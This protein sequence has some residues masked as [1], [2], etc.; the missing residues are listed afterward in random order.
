MPAETTTPHFSWVK[1]A[2]GGDASTWGV[3]LNT[4]FDAIDAVVWQ[5]QQALVPIGTILMF[6]GSTPPSNFLW[7]NGAVY[8]DTDVPSLAPILKPGG[9]IVYAGSDASHTAVPN[10]N[11]RV[12]VG[13]DFSSSGWWNLGL[14]GGESAHTLAVAETPV[15]K[16]TAYQDVHTH[17]VWQD[18][19]THTATQDAHTHTV[20]QDGH[21]HADSGHAHVDSGHTHADSGHAHVDSGHTHA[22]SGHTHVDSGHTH[23]DSGHTHADSGHTHGTTASQDP[24]THDV[25]QWGTF[26]TPNYG[27]RAD[28]AN[29][30][31]NNTTQQTSTASAAGVYVTVNVGYA[32]IVAA[33]ANI[34]TGKASIVAASANIGTGK[35]NIGT[36]YASLGTGKAN[37]GTGYASLG[38][39]QPA[40]HCDPQQPVITVLAVQPA[41]TADNRQPNVYVNNTGGGGAHNNMQPYLPVGFMIRYR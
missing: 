2:I 27:V 34:G 41:I 17:T 38:A 36:G 12:P 11:T 3:V 13:S 6:G 33:S 4:T 28:V 14:A 39:V 10:L 26:A 37:I 24:H 31:Q 35:A 19:H 30:F 7:C 22:D 1:P 9:K 16:H 18:A 8:L 23:A 29:Y 20:S 40:V 5:N 21:T 15:H 32:N 25:L